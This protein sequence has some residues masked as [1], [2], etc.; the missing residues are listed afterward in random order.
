MPPEARD[1]RADDPAAADRALA[2]ELA[3][4]AG[5]RLLAVRAGWSGD[6]WELGDAGD[7]AAQEILAAELASARPGD[8]VLSEEAADDPTRHTADRVWII[9]PLDGT[10][11]YSEGR[12]TGPCTS[13][14]GS[15]GATDLTVGVI[16]LPEPGPDPRLRRRRRPPA[17]RSGTCRSRSV[18]AARPGSR[19]RPPQRSARAWCRWGRP[20]RRSPRSCWPGGRLRARRRAVPVGLRG[21]GGHGPR[22]RHAHEPAGPGHRC[23]TTSADVYLPDLVV[24]RPELA[25][26]LMAAVKENM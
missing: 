1:A 21:P 24:A 20:A 15:A 7:R 4:A 18:A 2:I 11:E 23:G 6:R 26:R 12:M 5:E 25:P 9:D 8:A 16:A 3:R 13:R 19:S 14:C 22:G 17:R 10:R